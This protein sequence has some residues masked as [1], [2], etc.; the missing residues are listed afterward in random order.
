MLQGSGRKKA[1]NYGDRE[2][3]GE[4]LRHNIAPAISDRLINRQNASRETQRKWSNHTSREGRRADAS[5]K[6]EMPLRISLKVRTL[7]QRRSS[8]VAST[9]LVTVGSGLG[10]TSSEITPAAVVVNYG[11]IDKKVPAN[12]LSPL[13]LPMVTNS[14]L[15]APLD[16][17]PPPKAIPQRLLRTTCLPF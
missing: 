17:F 11:L 10:F 6:E 9:H 1:V 8:S 7:R 12:S 3:C 13:P 2:L 16:E 14:S 4:G 15:V 5:G